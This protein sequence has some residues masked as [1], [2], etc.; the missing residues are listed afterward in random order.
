MTTDRLD[1]GPSPK[2]DVTEAVIILFL[3]ITIHMGHGITDKLLGNSGS[4]LHTFLWHCDETGL[5]PPHP[6]LLTLY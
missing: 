1:N 4:A 3:A 5:I 6:L 2:P